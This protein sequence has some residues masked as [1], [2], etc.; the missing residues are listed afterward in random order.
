MRF[1]ESDTHCDMKRAWVGYG[2]R[3]PA[4]SGPDRD[5]VT[6]SQGQCKPFAFDFNSASSLQLLSKRKSKGDFLKIKLPVQ[7]ITEMA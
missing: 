6:C 3:R 1:E 4:G 2:S 7:S 5:H